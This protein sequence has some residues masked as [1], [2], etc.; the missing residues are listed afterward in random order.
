MAS[1]PPRCTDGRTGGAQASL[2]HPLP[3]QPILLPPR[4]ETD[5]DEPAGTSSPRHPGLLGDDK[6]AE[7]L[8]EAW[9]PASAELQKAPSP[10]YVPHEAR[11]FL[12]ERDVPAVSMKDGC[13]SSRI[14][15]QGGSEGGSDVGIP[16]SD[17]AQ[18]LRLMDHQQVSEDGGLHHVD[19]RKFLID[20]QVLLKSKSKYTM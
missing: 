1:S 19:M 11:L 16:R 8:V 6:G 10:S 17:S 3:A 7:F 14:N 18:S 13:R 9:D 15:L 2:V 20:V 5:E 4:G 12:S